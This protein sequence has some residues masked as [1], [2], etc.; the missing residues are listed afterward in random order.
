MSPE[1]ER[2]F[3]LLEV[4]K[5]QL[6]RTHSHDVVEKAEI[7]TQIAK[8]ENEISLRCAEENGEKILKHVQEISNNDNEV[9]RLNLWKLKQKIF[10][11]N[12]EVPTA[13]KNSN[14]DLVTNPQYL[15]ELYVQ[16]YKQRL[17]HR[18]VRPGL[19]VLEY[20][21]K[22]LFQLRL[23]LSKK[24]ASDPWTEDQLWA[25]LKSLNWEICRCIRVL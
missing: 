20:L 17:A 8:I 13:K 21:K 19:E 5:T 3:K 14:G 11:K 24:N 12:I 2:L 15:K 18:S 22:L 4:Q 25:V 1:L 6:A 10:P 16:T 9:N 23:F 7:E